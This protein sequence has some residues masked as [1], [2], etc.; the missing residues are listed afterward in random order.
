MRGLFISTITMRTQQKGKLMLGY[1]E[2]DVL[3]MINGL[4]SARLYINNDN[5]PFVDKQLTNAINLLEGLLEE[6]HI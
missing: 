4:D 1:K 3:E 6:G 2:Q 5:D